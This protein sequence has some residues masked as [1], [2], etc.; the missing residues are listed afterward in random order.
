MSFNDAEIEG[1]EVRPLKKF[2]DERGW[3]SELF[4]SDELDAEFF[5]AMSYISVTNPGVQRG[6]HEHVDQ[7]DYFCFIAGGTFRVG[8]WDNRPESSTYRNRMIFEVGEENPATV[9]VPKGVVHTYKNVSSSPGLVINCPNRLFM[10]ENR[11][12]E[13]DEIR[14]ENDPETPF[15]LD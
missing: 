12:S 4:R 9:L 7:A 6:P 1:V 11:A 15:R 8:L 2:V 10:G 14:H 13:I 3:L 5:P